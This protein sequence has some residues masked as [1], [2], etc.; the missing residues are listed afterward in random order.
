MGRLRGL[1]RAGARG[2]APVMGELGTALFNVAIGVL[3]GLAIGRLV[4]SRR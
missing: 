3:L 1:G 2:G 4:W